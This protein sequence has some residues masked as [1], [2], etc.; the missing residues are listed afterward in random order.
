MTREEL[1][2]IKK[3]WPNPTPAGF[4]HTEYMTL[5]IRAH[6]D[7]HALITELE[8]A[9]EEVQRWQDSFRSLKKHYPDMFAAI[10]KREGE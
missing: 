2:E 3:K 9:K 4:P 7:I 5:L 1:Q 8:A 10:W 6:I